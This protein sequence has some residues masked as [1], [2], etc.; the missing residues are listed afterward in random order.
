MANINNGKWTK[1]QLQDGFNKSHLLQKEKLHEEAGVPINEHGSTL[2]DVK[3]F[4]DHLGIQINIVDGDQF[5]ELIYTTEGGAQAVNDSMIYLYKNKNHFHVITSMPAFLWKDYYCH[6]CKKSYT[7]RDRHKCPSKCIA[8]FKYN[9]QCATKNEDV[10]TCDKCN[11]SF[12]GKQCFEEHLRNRARKGGKEDVVC[13]SVQKC[14]QCGRTVKGSEE[15]ICGYSSCSN[16][17]EYCD[18]KTHQ[19]YML[20]K[21]CK[22]GKCEKDCVKQ[23]KEGKIKEKDMCSIC[24]TYTEKYMFLDFECNQE[25]GTHKVNWADVQD[26][27]GNVTNFETVDDFCKFAFCKE[28]KGYTF[29]AHNAKGYEA[30]FILKYCIENGLKPYCIYAGTKIMSMTIQQYNIRIID[31]INFGASGLAAFPK[32]FVLKELKKGY[33]PTTSTNNVI[34]TTLAQCQVRNITGMIK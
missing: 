13:R 4:A 32:T 15:H 18:M 17:K 11:R 5:N 30:Q 25:T 26:F 2:E 3:Q 33:F 12:F 23:V 20:P 24:K 14:L 16:C 28:H 7:H 9:S 8:C 31:T 21:Q 29:M 6:T 10:I 22:G 19:C 34:K 1:T 27:E